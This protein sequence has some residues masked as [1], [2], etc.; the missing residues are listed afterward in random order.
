MG[1]GEAK[2][3][4]IFPP[5]K[6]ITSYGNNI[7]RNCDLNPKAIPYSLSNKKRQ[8]RLSYCAVSTLQKIVIPLIEIKNYDNLHT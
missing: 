4:R 6:K 8:V 3:L 7:I 1:P 5:G 2:I